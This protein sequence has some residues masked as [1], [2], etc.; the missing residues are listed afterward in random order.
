M[1]GSIVLKPTQV[2]ALDV[3]QGAPELLRHAGRS[4]LPGGGGHIEGSLPIRNLGC[5]T[6]RRFFSPVPSEGPRE[7]AL[8]EGTSAWKI[9]RTRGPQPG[10]SG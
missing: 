10:L 6:S 1:R 8:V 7:V 9:L 2:L 4:G 5:G 3:R